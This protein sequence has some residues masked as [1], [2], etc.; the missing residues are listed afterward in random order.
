MMVFVENKT[1]WKKIQD[2]STMKW[3]LAKVKEKLA[4]V[5]RSYTVT[6]LTRKELR[7]TRIHTRV[8]P[9]SNEEVEP[10]SD[11]QI[12]AQTTVNPAV[13]FSL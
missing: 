2:Q 11:G 8:I 12:M 7:H 13:V 6:A 3:K 9:Q 4:G 1:K 10:D 5:L